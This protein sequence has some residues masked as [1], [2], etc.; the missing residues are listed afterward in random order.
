MEHSDSFYSILDVV[1]I[2]NIVG[3]T[4]CEMGSGQFLA[5]AFLEYQMGVKREILLEIADFAKINALADQASLLLRDG[6][7]KARNLPEVG[8]GETRGFCLSKINAVYRISGLAG[9]KEVAN[10][11]VDCV[12]SMAVL[13]HVRRRE[14]VETLREVYRFMRVG[15]E[16]ATRL[17]SELHLGGGKIFLRS[18]GG[19]HTLQNGQLHKQVFVHGGG[20][21]YGKHWIYRKY[22]FIRKTCQP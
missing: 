22:G 7:P 10:G 14:F 15:G 11:E 16:P 8:A 17:T 21:H 6:Y 4:V 9:Y 13:E 18:L 2:D 20:W 19:W 5:N 12:F 1:G 3:K